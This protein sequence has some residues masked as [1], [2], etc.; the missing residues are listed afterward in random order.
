MTD[1]SDD[2]GSS[3]SGDGDHGDEALDLVIRFATALPDLHTTVETPKRTSVVG[4]K[5][6]IR[7]QLPVDL[8]ARRLRLIHAGKILVDRSAVRDALAGT[9]VSLPPRRYSRLHGRESD[10]AVRH[11]DVDDEDE[12]D[13]GESIVTSRKRKGKAPIRDAG[14]IREA[15]YIHCSL[16]DDLT[17]DELEREEASV[18]SLDRSISPDARGPSSSSSSSGGG[19]GGPPLSSTT[20]AA[21]PRGFDRLL[22][23]GFST[24]EI[25]VL[26]AQFLQ[27]QSY[28]HT[29]DTMPTAAELRLLEDRWIDDSAAG[30]TPSGAFG[31]AAVVDA[32][33]APGSGLDDML[34]GN[35][36]GFFW[37]LGAIVWLLREEGI[38]SRRRQMAVYTGILVNVAFSV[39]RV[40]T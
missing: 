34:W 6:Q 14:H 3:G 10:D 17:P 8:R 9:Y 26:R 28:T 16:G 35:V 32:G 29:P 33:L 25:A 2:D 37:P 11:H 7:A 1:L 13:D 21:A 31:D 39:L 20:T 36:L 30:P 22:S 19:G 4:L 12:D 18:R 27:L 23:A 38:W 5:C 15:T 40:A 24:Q